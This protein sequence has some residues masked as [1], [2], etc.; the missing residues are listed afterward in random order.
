MKP[1]AASMPPPTRNSATLSCSATSQAYQPWPMQLSPRAEVSAAVDGPAAAAAVAQEA[2]EY[3]S[4]SGVDPSPT[5]P[6]RSSTHDSPVVTSDGAVAPATSEPATLRLPPPPPPTP[7]L[8]RGKMPPMDGL[9][10]RAISTPAGCG[11]GRRSRSWPAHVVAVPH[12]IGIQPR[13]VRGQC[14]AHLRPD[15]FCRNGSRQ[16]RLGRTWRLCF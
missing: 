7:P 6:A 12:V 8:P 15:L 1:L 11:S 2:V 16:Q 10:L 14:G 9:L 5:D 13:Q 3:G 4:A